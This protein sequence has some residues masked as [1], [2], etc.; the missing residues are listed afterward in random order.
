M[1]RTQ[2]F[3]IRLAGLG[4]AL[5][6]CAAGPVQALEF[7]DVIPAG[8]AL[9]FDVPNPDPNWLMSTSPADFLFASPNPADAAAITFSVSNCFLWSGVTSCQQTVPDGTQNYSGVA[10]WTVSEINVPVPAEGL[11]LF[12]GGIANA[13]YV[14]APGSPAAPDYQLGDVE[15]LIDAGDFGG[16]VLSEI[17]EIFLPLGPGF[18]RT[19]FGTQVFEVGDA[20][21][22]GYRV[23]AQLAAGTPVPFA[24]VATNFTPVPEPGTALLVG[25]GLAILAGRRK[26]S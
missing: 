8:V 12:I 22:F 6:L 17:D 7:V 25:A 20:L 9:G 11:L 15:L 1:D 13:D 19:Y 2:T 10:T 4:M 3:K 21:T 23:N 18:D 14:P 16:S 5:A 24:N 26:R